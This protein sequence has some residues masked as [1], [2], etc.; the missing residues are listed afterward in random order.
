[1]KSVNSMFMS[2]IV[3]Y[4]YPNNPDGIKKA[5]LV[6]DP[7]RII[8]DMVYY[9]PIYTDVDKKMNA[10]LMVFSRYY[11]TVELKH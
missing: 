11:F 10:S 6:T 9:W 2:L 7:D 4:R 5:P 8:S 3:K 1:M